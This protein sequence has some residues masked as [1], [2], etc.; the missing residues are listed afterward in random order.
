MTP[1]KSEHVV[2]GFDFCSINMAAVEVRAALQAPNHLP[3]ATLPRANPRHEFD[4]TFLLSF[5]PSTPHFFE[6]AF[7]SFSL[8]FWAAKD[9]YEVDLGGGDSEV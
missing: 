7:L 3:D 6:F 4:A 9:K 2:H 1:H 8:R 5:L